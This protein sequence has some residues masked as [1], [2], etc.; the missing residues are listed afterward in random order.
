MGV[1]P[2]GTVRPLGS[3]CPL[4]SSVLWG[5]L[6]FRVF[7]VLLHPEVV[8]HGRSTI[9]Y[10]VPGIICPLGSSVLWG[11]LP[12]RVLCLPHRACIIDE[13]MLVCGMGFALILVKHSYEE[14]G[15]GLLCP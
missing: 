14:A 12:F 2:F 13:A 3:F 4:G 1:R 8:A 9:W 10:S 7:S 5:S 11:C 6:P 15:E